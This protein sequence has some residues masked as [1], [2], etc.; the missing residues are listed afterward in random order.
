MRFRPIYLSALV[1]TAALGAGC[2]VHVGDNGVSLDVAG[3]RAREEWSR[4]YSLAKGGSLEI[5][6]TNG[7]IVVNAAT[8][9]QVEVLAIRQARAGTEEEAQAL[10]KETAIAEEVSPNRVAI[11]TPN[12][13]GILRGRRSI[14][15]EYQVKVPAGVQITVK[16]ENGGIGLH[17]VDG[18]VTASTTN[19]GI[20]GTNLAGAVS[21]H[22]VN[23]GIV[24][25]VARVA[26]PIKLDAVNGG[27][28]LD[29]PTGV[30]ADLEAHAV[31]GGVSTDDGFAIT[32]SE[33]SRT[34][35]SGKLNAGGTPI[36]LSTVNGGVRI[37]MFK[38]GASAQEGDKEAFEQ[39]GATVVAEKK[40]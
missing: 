21:A 5:V 32:V 26:G 16:T 27:I 37:G 7:P 1:L 8:G 10:L 19:G 13:N 33:R 39:S 34:R 36:T 24:M 29:V 14:S 6:N 25:G 4:T 31:N 11:Q 35:V 23:G 17:D 3:G 22:I 30:N 12:G 28:R 20:R 38:P 15:V 18:D 9:S 40:R 2:D